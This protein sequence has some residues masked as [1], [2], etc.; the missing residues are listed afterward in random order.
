MKKIIFVQGLPGSG[1]TSF[2]KNFCKKNNRVFHIEID[3]LINNRIKENDKRPLNEYLLFKIQKILKTDFDIFL[4]DFY[5]FSKI[6]NL[7]LNNNVLIDYVYIKEDM[8]NCLNRYNKRT[9]KNLSLEEYKKKFKF[10]II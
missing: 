9:N 1:K 7:Y 3:A 10:N 8:S 4:L 6:K 5:D 2:C